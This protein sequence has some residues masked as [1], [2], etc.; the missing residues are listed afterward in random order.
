MSRTLFITGTGTDI[1]KSVLSL[2]VLLWARSR[3]LGAAYL[4][5]VQ[6]GSRRNGPGVYGDA[7]WVSDMHPDRIESG[8]VYTFADAVSPHLAAERADAW[9][10]ADWIDRAETHQVAGDARIHHAGNGEQH[11]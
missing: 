11:R 3:G 6:C 5:P 7:D 2:S 1:G 10:D 4:K 9:V 8:A